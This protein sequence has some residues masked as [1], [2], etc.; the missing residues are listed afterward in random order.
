MVGPCLCVLFRQGID[1]TSVIDRLG[2]LTSWVGRPVMEEC[3]MGCHVTFLFDL[4]HGQIRALVESNKEQVRSELMIP[5][6]AGI[7]L[8]YR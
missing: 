7:V 2:A 1:I 4:S 3:D 8:L 6:L 5:V